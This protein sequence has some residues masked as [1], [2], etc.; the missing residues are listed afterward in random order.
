MA[1]AKIRLKGSHSTI[2]SQT[3]GANITSKARA[4]PTTTK[5]TIMMMKKA[6]PS[7]LFC[8]E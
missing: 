1:S 5:P 6:D 7:P 2:C 4:R 8:P 3:G